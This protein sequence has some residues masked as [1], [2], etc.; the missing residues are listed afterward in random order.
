MAED[1]LLFARLAEACGRAGA[2]HPPQRHPLTAQP[3]RREAPQR[4]AVSA[5]I[6]SSRTLS[7]VNGPTTLALT[8]P[9]PATT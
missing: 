6:S 2:P 8:V 4:A 1:D 3:P 7:G 9:S 5:G